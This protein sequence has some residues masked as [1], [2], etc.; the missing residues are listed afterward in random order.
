MSLSLSFALCA[1]LRL[2][3]PTLAPTSFFVLTLPSAFIVHDLAV[4]IASLALAL[5]R[6]LYLTIALKLAVAVTVVAVEGVITTAAA[7]LVSAVS[8]SA[9]LTRGLAPRPAL[10]LPFAPPFALAIAI[11]IGLP[12]HLADAGA[13]YVVSAI[14]SH[15]Y[16][17]ITSLAVSHGLSSVATSV[18][19]PLYS[20]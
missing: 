14:L 17:I 19:F 9:P 10:A 2:L 20:H 1:D 13:V 16:A 7:A 18:F 15:M 5:G 6:G 3:L 12:R 11:T 8:K 4:T